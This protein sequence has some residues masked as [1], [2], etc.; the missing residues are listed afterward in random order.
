MRYTDMLTDSEKRA[1]I[2]AV[3]RFGADDARIRQAVDAVLLAHAQGRC[4]DLV[5]T[6]VGQRL[7]TPAQANEVRAALDTTHFDVDGPVDL[8]RGKKPSGPVK[9][10]P[11]ANPP[12]R[13]DADEDPSMLR[14]LGEYRI[15]RRL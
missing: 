6:L 11:A 4:A 13:S 14:V 12:A 5:D 7:L 8:P 9:R 1:V 10:A 2:L 3:S 15:L